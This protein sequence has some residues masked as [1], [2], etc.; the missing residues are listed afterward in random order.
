MFCAIEISKKRNKMKNG[1]MMQYFEWNMPNNGN[2]WN[3]LKEDAR[4]L[5][6]AGVTAVWI[7]PAY[8]ARK[9]DDEGYGTYDLY[10]LGEFDQKG[11]VRTKYGTKQEL[12]EMIGELHR[13]GIN[14]YLDAVMNHKA[15]ADHTEKCLAREVNPEQ[16][17]E[18]VT[19]P[20][21][22]ECWT[23]FDF[24]GRGDT[25]SPFKWHW[26]HFSGTDFNETNKKKGI[27]EIMG[28]GKSWSKGVDGE[29]GNYDYLMFADIDFDHPEVIEEMK[30]WGVWV[31]NELNLD[32]MRLDA[33]KHIN[34]KFIQHFLE[35]IRA[36]RG[37]KF[38][39]V[40]EYW[41][42]DTD[43]L[44]EYLANVQYEV[45]LFDVSLHYN[46]FHASQKGRDYDL[47]NLLAD[48]LVTRHP[49]LAVTFVDNHDSQ[50]N[51][52]LESQ[53]K[54]WFKPSAYALI[55]LMDKGYPCIFYGDYY[56]VKGK[57]SPHRT[58]LDILLDARRKYAYGKQ[59]DYF[60]H[61]NTVGFVRMGDEKHPGSGLALLISNGD[62]G[63]KTMNVGKE[64]KGEVWHDITGDRKEE[65]T[66]GDDGCACFPVS[67]GK[68]AVWV[69]KE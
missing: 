62:D 51:S 61:P 36:E 48:T 45:D 29:N 37:E 46:L 54:D 2:L 47:Q 11:T 22:I 59:T 24:P 4:H 27:Y 25:Y 33:I 20:Y 55:L 7:P 23:G 41:K 69:K 13:N 56:G 10:D 67:G 8:K 63:D 43:S 5:H 53:V 12:K 30:K 34:D 1:V 16:R 68:A 39:A 66:I 15:G 50:K 44:D 57:K 18:A 52:S 9:Q 60:D 17:E 38:Y 31:S 28:E 40:G 26:Y 19:K 49:E 42:N 64:R 14:V 65:I 3:Q 21:E 6:E 58:T 35:A 32:G